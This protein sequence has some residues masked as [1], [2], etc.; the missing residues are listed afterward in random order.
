M[1]ANILDYQKHFEYRDGGLYWKHDRGSQKCKGKQAG[2]LSSDGYLKVRVRELGQSVS[3]HRIIFAMHHGYSP[4]FVDHIDGNPSNNR[5]ENLRA[6]TRAENNRNS[7]KPS[8]NTSGIK[9]VSWHKA[10]KKWAVHLSVNNHKRFFGLYDDIELAELVAMEAR[11][12]YHGA[13]A[14]HGV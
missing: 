13:F 11:D 4:E 7:K 8:T 3:A 5:I 6:A 2:A 1:A 12:K 9:N 14:N 10:N